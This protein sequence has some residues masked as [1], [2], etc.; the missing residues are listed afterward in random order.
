MTESVQR[1]S[2]FAPSEHPSLAELLRLFGRDLLFQIHTCLPGAVKSVRDGAPAKPL[3]VDVQPGFRAVYLDHNGEED[4]RPLPVVHNA[5]VGHFS[6][7]GFRSGVKPLVGDHGWLI[8][9]ERVLEAWLGK[10]NV[11]V[12]PVWSEILG[13]T[14]ALF[15][16]VGPP[17]PAGLQLDADFVVG[18]AV[19]LN[20]VRISLAG[21]VTV[22]AATQVRVESTT[23]AT[24]EAPVINLGDGAAEA[25]V[26]GGAFTTL[27]NT[28]THGTPVGP[29]SPPATPMIPGTHTSVAVKTK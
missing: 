1:D 23:Q 4:S 25:L 22:K 17:G 14:G 2:A 24:V 11:P 10:G 26:K 18:D 3:A 6:G 15:L 21:Q 5:V 12:D 20:E 27:F 28:H 9:C 16:P 29:S 13:M 7:G 8:F 19:G